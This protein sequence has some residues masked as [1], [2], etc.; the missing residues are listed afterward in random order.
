LTAYQIDSQWHNTSYLPRKLYRNTLKR[1]I[2]YQRDLKNI[3][4]RS[5]RRISSSGIFRGIELLDWNDFGT[6]AVQD[7]LV[8]TR[9]G[10]DEFA[11][12]IAEIDPESLCWGVVSANFSRDFISGVLRAM[13][14][15][16][17]YVLANIARPDGI[18]EGFEPHYDT[19]KE[20]ITTS[21]IKL[22]AMHKM[23]RYWR[24]REGADLKTP[25]YIGDSGTD[26]ECLMDP[27]TIGVVMSEDGEGSL[28]EILQRVGVRILPIAEFEDMDKTSVLWARNFTEIVNSPLFNKT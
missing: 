27:E 16:K 9:K 13:N 15:R 20:L 1:E 19:P 26:I 5:F 11:Q 7:G 12:K 18:L 10:F 28:M 22:A 23:L 17:M 14:L 21:D 3:E 4:L 8:K 25:V 24:G 2:E 6:R